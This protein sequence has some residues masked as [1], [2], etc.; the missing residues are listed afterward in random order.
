MTKKSNLQMIDIELK[1]KLIHNLT[2]DNLFKVRLKL[3]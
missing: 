3:F 1:D 2:I